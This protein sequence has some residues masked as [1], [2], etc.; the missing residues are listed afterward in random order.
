M[1]FEGTREGKPS[2]NGSTFTEL[3]DYIY[4]PG[5]AK[6]TV[7]IEWKTRED[8]KGFR[9]ESKDPAG[10]KVIYQLIV[11]SERKVTIKSQND[12]GR[13]LVEHG[14]L[15]G[16]GKIYFEGTMRSE[17]GEIVLLSSYTLSKDKR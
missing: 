5:G 9:G 13:V 8:G 7:L 11:D 2:D 15:K 3:A 12:D 10:S 4:Q 14:T 6:S 17:T 16:D 1:E